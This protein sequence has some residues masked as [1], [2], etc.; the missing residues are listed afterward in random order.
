MPD[1]P[2]VRYE[3]IDGELY[4]T[5]ARNNDHQYVCLAL[6][7]ALH[8]WSMASGLGAA[9]TTPGLVLAEDNEVIP[10]LVWASRERIGSATD[11]KGHF[12]LAPELI[13]EVLAPG[14]VHEVLDR[15]VK[16]RVYSL[17]GAQEY[18]LVDPREQLVEVYRRQGGELRL[19]FAEGDT[20]TSPLLPGFFCPLATIWP[21]AL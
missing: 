14:R 20:L 21:L 16:L 11:E 3:V 12:T 7:A 2:G 15:E 18:W 9:Y 8:V 5:H 13:V 6:G 17:E 19:S 4:V 10:D 1:I